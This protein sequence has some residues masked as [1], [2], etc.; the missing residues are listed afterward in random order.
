[1]MVAVPVE[2]VA[3]GA[4]RV[5]ARTRSVG[6]SGGGV[7]SAAGGDDADIG[8][9]R[10]LESGTPTGAPKIG[11]GSCERG[12]TSAGGGGPSPASTG[13]MGPSGCAAAGGQTP[14]TADATAA[15]NQPTRGI[16]GL[17]TGVD[18]R[19]DREMVVGSKRQG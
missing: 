1:V 18:H 8:E 9:D 13:L 4:P 16:T 14:T 7:R 6:R 17:P 3:R 5:A 10:V 12:G 15:H 19:Q 11:G 2:S